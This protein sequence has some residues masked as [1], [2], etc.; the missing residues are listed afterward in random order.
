MKNKKQQQQAEQAP[1]FLVEAFDGFSGDRIFFNAKTNQTFKTPDHV[2]SVTGIPKMQAVKECAKA[3][4]LSLNGG[5][6]MKFEVKP[7]TPFVV[8]ENKNPFGAW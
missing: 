8:D 2:F 4:E 3:N 6:N 5:W 7:F 1:L